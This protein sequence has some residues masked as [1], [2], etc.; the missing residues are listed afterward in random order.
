MLFVQ[1][2]K[3]TAVQVLQAG[4]VAQN[5][6]AN[7]PLLPTVPSVGDPVNSNSTAEAKL[8]ENFFSIHYR[9][10]TEIKL[11]IFE[12]LGEK[13]GV[14]MSDFDDMKDY[15]DTLATVVRDI[16]NKAA[17]NPEYAGMLLEIERELGLDELGIS[18]DEVNKAIDDPDGEANKKL[19]EK[20]EAEY[21]LE[22]ESEKLLEANISFDE[23]GIYQ[24]L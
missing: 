9:D 23:L 12:A 4:S 15:A 14:N 18:I 19:T 1:N 7:N 16:R 10:A 3:M 6:A 20:I 24:I 17:T 2:Q 8:K 21:G 22:R 11:Q 5:A 13:L